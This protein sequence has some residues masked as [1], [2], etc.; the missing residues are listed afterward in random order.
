MVFVSIGFRFRVEVEAL[1]MVEPMGAYTKHRFVPVY[2]QLHKGSEGQKIIGYRILY[3][4]A[5]SGQS[6]NY[7]Y[8]KALVELEKLKNPTNS[9]LCE[10]C[11]NYEVRGG[12]TKRSVGR[13][14]S[15]EK[16]VKG[17]EHNKRICECIVEDITGYMQPTEALPERKTSPVSF[18]YMVPD[19]ES[20]VPKIEPQFHVRYSYE[21]G[22]P[23]HAPFT[24]E[25]GTAVYM[26]GVTIDVDKIGRL[27]DGSYVS[28]YE[29]RVTMAFKALEV[30]IEGLTFGAKKSRYLP[31]LET[32]GAVATISEPLPFTVS[33][34]R[35]YRNGVNYIITTV[36]RA[37]DYVNAL[38]NFNQRIHIIYMDKEGVVDEK[39]IEKIRSGSNTV[40]Y[41]GVDTVSQL[42][43]HVLKK[44]SS[45]INEKKNNMKF[46]DCR[47]LLKSSTRS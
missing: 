1:N 30:L 42:I 16:K 18:S 7:G 13:A 44:V 37:V 9:R 5:V 25:S 19:T 46:A 20:A 28:D 6:I 27:K 22:R 34:P 12:F 3:A 36:K 38:N 41:E 21:E 17:I 29:D 35:V 23:E 39:T 26:L 15:G 47:E 11:L 2:R 40:T 14:E 43:E 32:L 24:I 8:T 31:I 33:P 45:H 4:P 10:E